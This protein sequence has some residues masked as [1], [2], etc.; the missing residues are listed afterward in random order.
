MK[1]EMRHFTNNIYRHFIIIEHC[2]TFASVLY[3]ESASLLAGVGYDAMCQI[4]DTKGLDGM[5]SSW[6]DA[7]PYTLRTMCHLM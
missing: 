7:M 3:C 6:K 4:C 5:G 2:G 1:V